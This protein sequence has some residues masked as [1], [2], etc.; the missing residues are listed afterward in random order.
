MSNTSEETFPY[1]ELCP[2]NDEGINAG[3]VHDV[4]LDPNTNWLFCICLPLLPLLANIPAN[5]L[6]NMEPPCQGR[7][8]GYNRGQECAGVWDVEDECFY[9]IYC[10][11]ELEDNDSDDD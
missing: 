10:G 3:L 7:A 1:N 6:C 11:V 4:E 5:H 8:N 9:C 2:G